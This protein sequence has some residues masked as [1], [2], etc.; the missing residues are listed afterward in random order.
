MSACSTA[1]TPCA[2]CQRPA[3]RRRTF[4]EEVRRTSN[5]PASSF[6]P[7]TSLVR[8][9]ASHS[10]PKP[11]AGYRRARLS[12]CPEHL[13]PFA[14]D[15]EGYIASILIAVERGDRLRIVALASEWELLHNER[16]R[17]AYNMPPR[18]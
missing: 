13:E 11:A 2:F 6:P 17:S 4:V 3:S 16:G 8:L 7:Q 12:V 14:S 5:P 1:S 18:A 9:V 10:A 15:E